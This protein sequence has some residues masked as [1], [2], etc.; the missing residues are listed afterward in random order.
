MTNQTV[1]ELVADGERNAARVL[2]RE[3]YDRFLPLVRRIAMKMAR[4]VPREIPVSDLVG[5]GWVGLVEAF[6]RAPAEMPSDEFEAYASYRIRGAILDYLRTFDRM[7]RTTRSLSRRIATAWR[8][9]SSSLGRQ[10]EEAEVAKKLGMGIDAYRDALQRVAES[11]MARLEVIDFEQLQS[12]D[13]ATPEDEVG[14][15]ML[16]EAVANAIPKLP[17]RLQQVLALYYQEECTLRQIGE[18][19]GVTEARACQLHSEAIHRLRA[20]IGI[21]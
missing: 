17:P 18:V 20:L 4:K 8:E 14:R 13:E 5:C 7:S 16:R 19:L 15:Q 6:S 12:K 1:Q 11:G 9:A 3:D 10:P 2:S 21:S